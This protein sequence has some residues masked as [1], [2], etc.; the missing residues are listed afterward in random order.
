MTPTEVI[1]FIDSLFAHSEGVSAEDAGKI[2]T[3][4]ADMYEELF[5][6]GCH[7]SSWITPLQRWLNT[8]SMAGFVN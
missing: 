2:R 8:Y 4:I 6:Q 5:L 7:D 3:H 1:R